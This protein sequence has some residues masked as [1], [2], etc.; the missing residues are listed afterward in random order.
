MFLAFMII[1]TG[2]VV[3]MYHFYLGPQSTAEDSQLIHVIDKIDKPL[4][5][6]PAVVAASQGSVSII[7]ITGPLTLPALHNGPI[8]P[9]AHHPET[10]EPDSSHASPLLCNHVSTSTV[11]MVHIQANRTSAMSCD[12]NS[13][14]HPH[15][16][17]SVH[18]IGNAVT[19]NMDADLK[20]EV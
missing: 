19:T 1:S 4:D 10:E 3:C 15:S 20:P 6:K 18:F 14:V 12:G 2:F 7:D 13:H 17:A 11:P 9:T 5:L 16:P 8:A